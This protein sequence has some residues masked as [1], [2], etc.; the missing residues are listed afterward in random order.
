MRKKRSTR[1][2]EN[3]LFFLEPQ[4]NLL[5]EDKKLISLLFLEL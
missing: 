5:S 1:A 3:Y 4:K 2:Y